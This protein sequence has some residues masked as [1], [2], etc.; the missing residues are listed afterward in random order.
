MN[1]PKMPLVEV[2]HDREMNDLSLVLMLSL[3][4]NKLPGH[5]SIYS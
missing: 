4:L 5:R 3:C 1:T 2:R